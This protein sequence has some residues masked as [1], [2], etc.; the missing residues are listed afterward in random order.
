MRSNGSWDRLLG[1]TPVVLLGQAPVDRGDSIPATLT[2]EFANPLRQSTPLD[3]SLLEHSAEFGLFE[4]GW[5]AV[6]GLAGR[7]ILPR[8]R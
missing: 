4:S 7:P 8:R 1:E 6:A 3:A 5:R 2:D